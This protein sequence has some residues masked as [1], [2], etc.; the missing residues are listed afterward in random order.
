[1][2][3][4][5]YIIFIVFFLVILS[6]VLSSFLDRPNTLKDEAIR[7]S[8]LAACEKIEYEF[9]KNDC[10]EIV[11]KKKELIKNCDEKKGSEKNC[12]NLTR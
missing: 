10:I 3:K 9:I 5:K 4:K 7:F 11:L 8:D 12:Y 6:I 2:F 1:M